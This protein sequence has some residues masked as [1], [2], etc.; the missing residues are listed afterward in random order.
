VIGGKIANMQRRASAIAGW[1]PD[2][3]SATFLAVLLGGML[4]EL[5]TMG[6]LFHEVAQS[7]RAVLHEVLART[8]I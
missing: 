3:A 1:L 7:L 4:A 5:H 2:V 8:T 6:D